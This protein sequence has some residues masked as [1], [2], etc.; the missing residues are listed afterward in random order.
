MADVVLRSSRL[1]YN[2]MG[3]QVLGGIPFVWGHGLTS[4]RADEDTMPLIGSAV[5]GER[6]QVVRYD[7]RGHGLSSDLSAPADGDWAAF[8]RDQI[9]LIDHLG[10]DDV[11]LGGA[12][13]GMGTALHAALSLGD[14][15]RGLVLVIPPTAWETRAAQVAVYEQMAAAIE[16][17]GTGVLEAIARAT[18][19]P[20][21]FTDGCVC[22]EQRTRC[23]SPRSSAGPGQRIS[24]CLKR[25]QRLKRRLSCWHGPAT[26]VVRSVPPNG[27]AH[28][29]RTATS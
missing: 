7:A 1:L 12:S 4:S 22:S 3:S 10:L 21:P 24:R 8:A 17:K 11:V 18:P 23:D 5:I 15:M 2:L 29:F 25:S 16:R 6:C 20:D 26:L 28:C 27:W 9:G 19:P 14:R 13:M